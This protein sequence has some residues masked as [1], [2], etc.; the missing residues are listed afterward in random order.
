MANEL[1]MSLPG[2]AF[3][4]AVNLAFGGMDG[5]NLRI[6]ILFS[7]DFPNVSGSSWMLIRQ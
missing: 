4:F 7:S 5:P 2:M 3:L 6:P 1:S